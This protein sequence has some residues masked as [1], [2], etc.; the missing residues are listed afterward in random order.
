V[1]QFGAYKDFI[2]TL[3]DKRWV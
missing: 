3:S 2:R 1:D